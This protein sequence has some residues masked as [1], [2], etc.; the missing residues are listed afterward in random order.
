VSGKAGDSAAAAE[1]GPKPVSP[2]EGK[3]GI[4]RRLIAAVALTILAFP[5]CAAQWQPLCNLKDLSGWHEVLGGKWSVND[6]EIVGETGDG[7]YG[8]LVTDREYR[9]FELELEFKTEAPGN[10]GVQ[11]RSHVV[12]EGPGRDVPRMKGYQ[13]EVSPSRGDNTG[14]VYGEGTGRGWLAQPPAELATVLKEGE[15]NRYRITA[16]E[17]HITTELN[18]VKMVE[19][20]DDR[21]V[22]GIIALQVHAGRTPVRV[23]WRNIRINDLGFGPGWKPLFNGKDF[24]GWKIHGDEKWGVEDGVIV[25]ESGAGGYGYLATAG[26]YRDFE[27]RVKFKC[28]AEGNSGVFIHSTLDGT[29]IRGV[30]AEIDPTPRNLNAGLYESGG[31]GWLAQPNEDART[32]MRFDGWNDLWVTCKGNRTVT[33]LN[34]FQAVDYTDPEPKFTDGVIALQLHSGGGAKVRWKDLYVREPA[35]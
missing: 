7:R 5:A 27:V 11:F 33:Y 32:L 23:R 12:M 16:V 1:R 4:V 24:T 21:A 30:Q 14:G 35:Q 18:G 9:N 29:D 3:E 19:F 22:L 15:W 34:G 25:G 26:T 20:D 28:D 31:R 8:W 13:A 2:K 6:G 17:T 10:S